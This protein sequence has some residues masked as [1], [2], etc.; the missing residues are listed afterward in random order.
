VTGD[1]HLWFIMYLF[2]VFRNRTKDDPTALILADT[3]VYWDHPE[4]TY[5]CPDIA[6]IFGVKQQ[7]P[8]WRSFFV[9]DEGVRPH[10]ITEVVSPNTRVNDVET[11]LHQYHLAEVPYYFI[12]DRKNEDDDWSL[13]GYQW[14]P[15]TY[16]PLHP[17]PQGRLWYKKLGILLAAEGKSI[18]CYD[19]KTGEKILNYLD[20]DRAN[21]ENSARAEAEKQ[22]AEAEKQRAEAEKQRA[23]AEKQRAE[24]EKQR[25][26]ALEAELARLRG[27]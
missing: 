22:R 25:A 27:V 19:G 14:T 17:D 9:R 20:L 18:V 15:M 16:V 1:M 2:A 4:L 24:A 13:R 23:E 3:G 26:D 21:Q 8:E 7:K 12:F 11:K 10:S 5:H 6:A